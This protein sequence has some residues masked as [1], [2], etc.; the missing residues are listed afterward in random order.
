MTTRTR[1]PGAAEYIPHTD[2]LAAAQRRH[3]CDLY[4]D[5]TQTVFGEGAAATDRARAYTEFVDDL[6]RLIEAG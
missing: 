6:T 1:Y 2:D 4:R 3:G 5:A